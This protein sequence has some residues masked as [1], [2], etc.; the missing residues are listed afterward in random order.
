MDFAC[1]PDFSEYVVDDSV[2]QDLTNEHQAYLDNK[3]KKIA[4]TVMEGK[5]FLFFNCGLVGFG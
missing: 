4:R 3:L 2:I 1:P 5:F